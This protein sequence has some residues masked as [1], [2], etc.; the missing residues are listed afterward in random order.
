MPNHFHS[1]LIFHESVGATRLGLT[2]RDLSKLDG[3]PLLHGPRP[4]SL[5]AIMAQFKSRVTKRLW[6]IPFLGG[7]P[8]WQRNYYEHIIRNDRDLQ[9]K[10]D[11]IESNPLLWSEDEGNL[12]N[13]KL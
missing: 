10:T 13:A 12:L 11:Y 6:K 1:I 2:E 5:G 9:N 7:T 8:I 4:T 3:S